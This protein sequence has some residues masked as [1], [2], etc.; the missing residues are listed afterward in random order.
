LVAALDHPNTAQALARLEREISRLRER[1]E[2][3]P[4]DDG[5]PSLA[6]HFAGS[7][8]WRRYEAVLAYETALPAAASETLH[9][10]RIAIKRLRYAVEFFADALSSEAKLVRSL[11]VQFQELLGQHQDACVAVALAS[12]LLPR[13]ADRATL[14]AFIARRREEAA[15]LAEQFRSRWPELG[16]PSFRELL[17]RALVLAPSHA[18]R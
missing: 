9:Q 7:L 14:D 18:P 1:G 17:G 3:P 12:A 6:R 5:S 2:A 8:L 10:L 4:P 11:L 16:G 15:T 13:S